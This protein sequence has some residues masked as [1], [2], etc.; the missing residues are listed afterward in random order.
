MKE[1][2]RSNQR[3]TVWTV[4]IHGKQG[5]GNQLHKYRIKQA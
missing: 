1:K 3:G 5:S 2:I 4:A